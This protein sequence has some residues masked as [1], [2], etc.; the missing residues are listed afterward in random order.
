MELLIALAEPFISNKDFSLCNNLI[1][2]ADISKIR[3][4][5]L[6]LGIGRERSQKGSNVTDL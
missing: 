1:V 4:G 2:L 5:L 6:T 3:G